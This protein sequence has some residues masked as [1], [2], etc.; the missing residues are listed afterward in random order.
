MPTNTQ[1]SSDIDTLLRLPSKVAVQDYLGVDDNT[2]GVAANAAAILLKAP[3]DDATFTGTTTIPSADITT[4]DFN[5]G[6]LGGEVSWNNTEKTL[7]LVTGSDSVTVQLGQEVVLYARNTSGATLSDGQVV[8][9]SGS[10]GNKPTIALAQA[11]TV[12]NAR[13]TIGVVTQI[14]PNNSNGFVTLLG[15]V[16]DLVLDNGTYTEG[17]VVYLSGTVAGGITVV[18]PDIS[19][20]IGHVLATSNGGNTNG[21]LEVQINNEAAVHELQQSVPHNTDSVIICNQGDNIQ[22]KYD[23]AAALLPNSNAQ[24]PL[25]RASLIVMGGTY[26]DL[27]ASNLNQEHFVDIIGIGSVKINSIEVV[28]DLYA[29]IRN[30]KVNSFTCGRILGFIDNIEVLTYGSCFIDDVTDVGK[31][32]NS[33][34]ETCGINNNYGTIKNVYVDASIFEI[35]GNN[36]GTIQSINCFDFRVAGTNEGVI[37]NIDCR[38][39]F[40][41][42]TN[43]KLI[44]SVNSKQFAGSSN[45]GIIESS[46]GTQSFACSNN[47]GTIRD[48]TGNGFLDFCT[49]LGIVESCE[50]K[51]DSAYGDTHSFGSMFGS[52]NGGTIRDCKSY[53]TTFAAFGPQSVFG[54]T[55]GCSGGDFSFAAKSIYIDW[56]SA[57]IQGTYRDCHGGKNSFFGRNVSTDGAKIIQATY[58]N[59]TAGENSWGFVNKLNVETHFGGSAFN[60][61]GGNKS[62]A[63]AGTI[64]GTS[65]IIDG[66]VIEGCTSGGASFGTFNGSF[67]AFNEGAVLRCRTTE[68]GATPFS[69]TGTGVVRLC[70]KGNFDEVNLG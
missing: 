4:A 21:V 64:G 1:V 38:G 28:G 66:A 39:D 16:R 22:T 15:K 44:T 35:Q 14:I 65:K 31:I 12:A 60:C 69:A 9:I 61:I 29:D 37:R 34:F 68:T 49:N 58:I 50:N 11:N 32:E 46:I 19:V 27:L 20:E 17:D 40:S 67:G 43:N 10:Q 24:S 30:I 56:S 6:G 13:K 26:G 51:F 57:A 63:A 7:D 45:Y 47:N 52:L 8:M 62:F 25:N 3:I 54:L 53:A 41:Y 42:V 18:E 2:A 33:K 48:C 5:A 70:L 23:E 36:L 59:C 55:Q